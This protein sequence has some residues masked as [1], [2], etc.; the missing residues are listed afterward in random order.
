V[1]IKS[2]EKAFTQRGIE[3]SQSLTEKMCEIVF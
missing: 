3:V 2:K 1:G